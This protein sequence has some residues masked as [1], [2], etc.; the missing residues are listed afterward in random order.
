MAKRSTKA[1]READNGPEL[2]HV[3]QRARRRKPL[4]IRRFLEEEAEKQYHQSKQR[5][6]AFEIIK[7]WADLERKGTLHRKER[8]LDAD[9]L[10]EVF[11]DALGYKTAT[12]SPDAWQLERELHV[13]GVGSADAALGDF[14]PGPTVPPIVVI[15]LKGADVDLDRSKTNGRTAVQQCWDYLNSFESCRWGVVS[16]FVSFRLYCK[17]KTPAE[18]EEFMLQELLDPRKFKQFWCLF[19]PAGLLPN[20]RP[21]PYALELLKRT[22]S[23][24]RE[25]GDEL[26]RDYSE[27]RHRLIEHLHKAQGK[28]LDLSLK[29]A[30]RL[31]DRIVFIAFCEDRDLLPEKLIDSTWTNVPKL[32]RV[33]NPRWRNFLDV[34]AAIDQGDPSDPYLKDGYNGGLFAHDPDVDDLKLLTDDWTNFFRT[35]GSYDFADEVQLEVLGHLF[36]KSVAEIESYQRGGLFGPTPS[37]PTPSMPATL[38]ARRVSAGEPAESQ[39]RMPKSAERKRLGIYYTPPA[40]TRLI[41]ERTLQ[42]LID[43]RLADLQAKR[44]VSAKELA[45][46]E[47]SPRLAD[48]WR[49]A[50][51]A[52]REIKVCDPACGSGAFLIQAYDFL[53]EQYRKLADRVRDHGGADADALE[54]SIPDVLLA[55][56]LFGVDLSAEAVEI[57]QLALWIRSARKG[58]TL[59]DLS[60]HVLCGNS[61]VTDRA[62]HPRA[63]A[64]SEAFPAIFGRAEA[65]FDAI[66]GNP[67]WERLKVQERE[68]FSQSAPE[69]ASSVSAADRRKLIEKLKTAKPELHALY[70]AALKNADQVM[71]HVR[72]AGAYPL[73]GQG[74]VN[75]YALFAELASRLV[76]PHGRVGLLVPSG[77]ATDH[78][79]KEFF[80]GLMT[81]KRLVALY[82]F[83]NRLRVFPDVDGRFKF[84]V[85]LFGG[86]ATSCPAAD[87][88]FF[89]HAVEELD[90]AKRHIKLSS[91][92]LAL[93]NPNTRTSPIFRSKQDA[94]LTKAIY[95][96]VP[97]LIDESRDEGGNPWGIRYVRMFDQTNDAELFTEPAELER[98]GF[99]RAGAR[100]T[101]GGQTFLPLYEAK[102]VQA[103]DHRAAS[104]VVAGHNWVRQGQTEAT[105][106]VQHQNPEF[107][108]LPRWWVEEKAVSAALAEKEAGCFFLGFKDITSPT[109]ER[110]MIASF[111][112][113]SAATNHF[114][115]MLNA[116]SAKLQACLLGNLNSFV[117]DYATRQKIGGVT[118]NFF[119]VNQLPLFPPAKYAEKCPWAKGQKLE[120]WISERVLKLSCTANDLIPLAEAAGFTAKVHRWNPQE[121]AELMA[122]LDAA[123]FLLYGLDR[124]E[125]AYVLST[126]SGVADADPDLFGQKSKA[127]LIL[128][129]YDRLAAAR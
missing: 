32:R 33:I 77:I 47:P 97:I 55:D 104:V 60:K 59:A 26:Y 96:R 53:E 95:K 121:R 98:Q 1:Q 109:N 128:E 21:E 67:P 63:F 65:G 117:L 30:Q 56:N 124:E 66:V 41:V 76:A 43:A 46:A 82:D 81:G 31:L 11:G 25:V 2:F 36:E 107:V 78:S 73:T 74:D 49:E 14:R 37:D 100:W 108:A 16:N 42:P 116:E 27:N 13:P 22:E 83:E 12:A 15:E 69:I 4:L 113:Y 71:A 119:I 64:W 101:K 40:F 51:A 29:I 80:G 68:F 45:A 70:E 103:Y 110:T 35:I 126:F 72:S 18:F 20:A 50:F 9:F 8:A 122:E 94:E 79:T 10:V 102:M 89:A 5:E 39:P 93:L 62:A 129:T 112:P 90:D 19:C 52:L 54:L 23:R 44:K 92:D 57:T 118:L 123:F 61:L 106:L 34:F 7:K 99:R 114:I 87:F 105:T 120:K 75:T 86:A 88:V 38:A 3:A 127:A 17:Q 91:K 115:I 28:P 24:Q 85:L 6:R 58:K 125:A 48:F 111:I 84:C